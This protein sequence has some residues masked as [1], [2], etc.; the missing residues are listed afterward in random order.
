M[1]K[2]C[3]VKRKVYKRNYLI[4]RRDGHFRAWKDSVKNVELSIQI[5]FIWVLVFPWNFVCRESWSN[6]RLDSRTT[7]GQA[8][9][10]FQ[11]ASVPQM[12][13]G[14]CHNNSTVVGP[15]YLSCVE[16]ETSLIPI[17]PPAQHMLSLYSYKICRTEH[18]LPFIFSW[19]IFSV[20][21]CS[22]V[23]ISLY[24]Y[25]DGQP[26]YDVIMLRLF[27]LPCLYRPVP[28]RKL[29]G[30]VYKADVTFWLS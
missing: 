7:T 2:L 13:Q 24:S 6:S 10:G 1:R 14:C 3:G 12:G 25:I 28:H 15:L 16:Q 23:F 21:I 26:C 29:S 27:S 18:K 20:C 17:D 9:L 8:F 5:P 30:I 11:L 19:H 4:D 22:P